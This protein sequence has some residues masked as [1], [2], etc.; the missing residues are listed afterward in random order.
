[1]RGFLTK[2]ASTTTGASAPVVVDVTRELSFV[3]PGQRGCIRSELG[4]R[5]IPSVAATNLKVLAATAT[6]SNGLPPLLSVVNGC[7]V[8]RI[9]VRQLWPGCSR[10]LGE[11]SREFPEFVSMA[12]RW[13]RHSMSRA[14]AMRDSIKAP[15]T[16]SDARALN[17]CAS[18]G[19][20]YLLAPVVKPLRSYL[21]A[22]FLGIWH[23]NT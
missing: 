1:M 10:H 3:Y 16:Q 18:I 8:G 4:D 2:H 22:I 15:I 13:R 17:S 21:I 19:S 9:R 11:S 23:E 6:S 12:V 14:V 5:W 20:N 7:G